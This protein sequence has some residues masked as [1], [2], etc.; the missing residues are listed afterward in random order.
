MMS[1]T[2]QA[3]E[4]AGV[5]IPQTLELNSNTLKLNGAGLR[6]KFFMDLYVGSL[7]VETKTSDP[8]NSDMIQLDISVITS[9]P[10]I[11]RR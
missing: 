10:A 5:T 4:V 9:V 1:F 2:L 8:V 11:I 7:Y 3:M 6:R